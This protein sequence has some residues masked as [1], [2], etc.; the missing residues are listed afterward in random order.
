[1][2]MDRKINICIMANHNKYIIAHKSWRL[3]YHEKWRTKCIF[4][5]EFGG[6][7][8]II[9]VILC[10]SSINL[11]NVQIIS[12]RMKFYT[13]IKIKLKYQLKIN[14]KLPVILQYLYKTLNKKNIQICNLTA[15][16]F[17]SE[18]NQF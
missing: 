10:E 13:N 18:S 12:L 2:L 8:R 14:K 7:Y 9:W 5:V 17:K 11:N 4:S 1:M 3:K 6:L 15:L 16:E